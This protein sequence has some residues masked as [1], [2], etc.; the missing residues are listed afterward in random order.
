MSSASLPQLDIAT[1]DSQIFWLIITFSI[2][3]FSISKVFLPNILNLIKNREIHIN[4]IMNKISS[5]DDRINLLQDEHR[6]IAEKNKKEIDGISNIAKKEIVKIQQENLQSIEQNLKA[7]NNE[8]HADLS[9]IV[10]VNKVNYE[11]QS[12][13]IFQN[14]ANIYG[15][16]SHSEQGL[17][18]IFNK[19]WSEKVNLI[20]HKVRR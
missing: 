12:M 14:F 5:E 19:N 20:M 15:L 1:Y 6:E 18:V 9:A 13:E 16:Q 8:L 17:R 3:Y 2:L 10:E 11:G 7:M 4:E